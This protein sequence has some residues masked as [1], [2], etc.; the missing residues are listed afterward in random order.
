MEPI[1]TDKT[2]MLEIFNIPLQRSEMILTPS[3]GDWQKAE[4]SNTH[5]LRQESYGLIS[6]GNGALS[7]H[8]KESS[9]IPVH[10]VHNRQSSGWTSHTNTETAP[11]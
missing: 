3:L 4:K 2:S 9:K 8:T 5:H 11:L 7:D 1:Q 6:N 10:S